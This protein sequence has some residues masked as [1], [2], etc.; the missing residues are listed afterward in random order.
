[1]LYLNIRRMKKFKYF[2]RGD[3]KKEQ[4]GI[5]KAKN[6]HNAII[7]STK[8]KNLSVTE[9]N[10]LFEIEEVKRKKRI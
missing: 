3:K 1:M 2:S 5:I 6:I 8:L 7:K 9:F 4:V 10:N